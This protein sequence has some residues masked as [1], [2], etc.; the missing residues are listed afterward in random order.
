MNASCR[1]LFVIHILYVLHIYTLEVKKI[2]AILNELPLS[3][4]VNYNMKYTFYIYFVP[5]KISSQ[6]HKSWIMLCNRLYKIQINYYS[7]SLY[8]PNKPDPKT[9]K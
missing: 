3:N 2:F 6:K 4:I 9:T 8:S 1:C 5:Q 7:I